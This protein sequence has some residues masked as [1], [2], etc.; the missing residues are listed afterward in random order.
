[1]I[2]IRHN[3]LTKQGHRY[4]TPEEIEYLKAW[5]HRRTMEQLMRTLERNKSAIWH[6]CRDLNI[7]RAPHQDGWLLRDIME[8]LE[9][10]RDCILK[11]IERGWLAGAHQGPDA[12]VF[13][14]KDKE[15]ASFLRAHPDQVSAEI[16]K[17]LW[18]QDILLS[19]TYSHGLGELIDMREMA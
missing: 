10:T 16:M 7:S 1:M 14:F 13:N 15:I 8:G 5:A 9:V 3:P 12:K 18:V 17:S 4:W 6:K 2:K 11:W 19:D